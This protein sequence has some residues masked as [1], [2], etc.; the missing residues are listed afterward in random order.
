MAEITLANAVVSAVC[1]KEAAV[2]FILSTGKIL[3]SD[4]GANNKLARVS[5]GTPFLVKFRT[6]SLFLIRVFT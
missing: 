3:R 5:S 6:A 2:S 4:T 1:L